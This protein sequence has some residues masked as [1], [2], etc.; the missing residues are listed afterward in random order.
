[1]RLF[2]RRRRL[3]HAVGREIEIPAKF[4]VVLE[5]DQLLSVLPVPFR[6][7]VNQAHTMAAEALRLSRF[8]EQRTSRLEDRLEAEGT[9]QERLAALEAELSRIKSVLAGSLG[10]AI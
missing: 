3:A 10:R 8:A 6:D 4:S 1:M 7:T 5:P 9:E 2:R